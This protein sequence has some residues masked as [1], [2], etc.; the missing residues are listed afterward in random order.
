M[1]KMVNFGLAYGMS[2]FGL[3]VAGEHPAPG[4]AG[5]HQLLLRGVLGDQLLHDGDQGAGQEPGLRRDAARPQAADPGA[6]RVEP[7]AARRRRA[8]GDQHADPGHGG[9]HPE[10]RDDPGRRA[11]APRTVCAPAC[12]S[13]STTSCCSRCR[14]T[15]SSAL[16]AMVRETMEAALPLDV[17][18]IVDVKVGD[19]WEWMTPLTR[20]GR[21]RR[22]GRRV[23][24][25]AAAAPLAS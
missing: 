23:P 2:D 11:A 16:A 18:L 22:R 3:A 12:C 7:R 13:R 9:G 4:G 10:D 21:H 17:P 14:A 6:A 5:V 19:D 24:P 15:R 25:E 20:A 1:A 8:D